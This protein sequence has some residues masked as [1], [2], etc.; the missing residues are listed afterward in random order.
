MLRCLCASILLSLSAL[1]VAGEDAASLLAR[2]KARSGGSRWDSVTSLV[3]SGEMRAAGLGGPVETRLDLK[4]GRAVSRYSLGAMKGAEGYD[5]KAGWEQ[6]PGGE[7]GVLDDP[8][9]LREARTAAWID[10]RAY[11]FPERGAATYAPVAERKLGDRS[12]RVVQATPNEGEPVELWFAQDTGLLERYVTRVGGKDSLSVDMRDWRSVDGV[13]VP[14]QLDSA[15]GA[16]DRNRVQIH[17]RTL[18]ANLPLADADFAPPAISERTHIA[19][20]SG[21]VRVPFRLARDHIHVN[22]TIDGKPVRMLVDTGGMNMLL[23]AAARRLGLSTEGHIEGRGTGEQSADVSIAPARTLQLGGVSIDKPVFYQFDFGR[24]PQYE[25]EDFDGVIGYELF[26]RFGVTIDYAAQQLTLM[27]PDKFVAPAKSQ[28]FVFT[29]SE[30]IPIVQARIDGMPVRLSVDTGSGSA[31]DLHSPFG[32]RQGLKSIS[33]PAAENIVGWGVGGPVRGW[34]V[35]L[36]TLQLGDLVL[37]DVSASLFTGDKGAYAGDDVDANL[38]GRA[39][40]HFTV[41][42]DYRNKTMYLAPNA[43]YDAAFDYD[44]S[45][46]TLIREG[47]AIQVYEVLSGGPAAAAG[48]LRGDVLTAIDGTPIAKHSLTEWREV[49]A[50]AP[51]GK[52]L[53]IDYRRGNDTGHAPLQ[54]RDL[55]PAHRASP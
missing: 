14:Y 23:P 50:R 10:A 55:V 49:L 53:R 34:P 41:G 3:G 37:H 47:E 39:L 52:E 29:L 48:L 4:R 11:W 31:V 27:A 7:V 40:K 22:A 17:Y 45:G 16:D 12:F 38:G 8:Q 51:L 21:I 36:G 6:D 35:R 33:H 20:P 44:R 32:K 26:Q 13:L 42:F 43:Q 25:G 19:D 15:R 18:K 5:G 1:A 46:L 30:R 28:A 9:A 54:P 24:L 2:A